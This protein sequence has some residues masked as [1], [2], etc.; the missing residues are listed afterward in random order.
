MGFLEIAAALKFLSNVDLVWQLGILNREVFLSIWIALA[1]VTALYLLGRITLS[2]DTPVER[3]GVVRM[4]WAVF[5]IAGAF[6]LF[7]G[8]IGAPL[9]EL[10]AFLPPRSY[11][12]V[13]K[14]LGELGGGGK[15]MEKEAWIPNLEEGLRKAKEENKNVFIDFT[16]YACTNC[17]WMEANI[18]T[19]E[20]VQ[21]EF[22][23]FVLV[24]LY[25]DGDGPQYDRNRL[26]EQNRFGTIALPFYAILSPNDEEI[27]RFPGLTRNASEFVKFLSQGAVVRKT[28]AGF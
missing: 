5:F 15:P 8:L 22:G 4:L 28:T 10:D 9:G 17:R 16:G 23:K 14:W 25:T 20:D 7:T 6:F 13:V 26:L 11:S 2:H 12:N 27:A 19:R 24:R 18:F 21:K 3:L 1:V